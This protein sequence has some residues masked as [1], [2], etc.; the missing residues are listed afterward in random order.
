MMLSELGTAAV[1]VGVVVAAPEPPVE[2]DLARSNQPAQRRAAPS[3]P[4]RRAPS[5]RRP[6]AA[7]SQS[8][9]PYADGPRI[10]HVS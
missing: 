6:R 4:R 9:P 7:A 2:G 1:V 10:G 3:S 5:P 8:E